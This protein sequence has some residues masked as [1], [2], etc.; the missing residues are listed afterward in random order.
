MSNTLYVNFIGIDVSKNN[1]D[2]YETRTKKSYRIT[3]DA[4]GIKS[5]LKNF[6]PS[7]DLL[8]LIDLTGGYEAAIV[9]HF[10]KKGYNVHRAQGRK[11]RQFAAS[12]GQKAKTDRIDAKML[13]I[14]GEK[15]QETLRLYTV[16]SNEILKELIS[17]REDLKS[18]LQ[19]ENNRKAHFAD[20]IM[21]RSIKKTIAF[22]KEEIA[23]VEEETKERIKNNP[24]LKEKAKAISSVKSVG[25]KTTMSLLA[26]LPELGKANRRQIA[27]L[28]GVAPYANNS[29]TIHKNAR[30]TAGRPIVKQMLFMCALGAVRN[31]CVLKAFYEKLCSKRK[32]KM[33]ALVAVMRKLLI[34][35]NNRCKDFYLQRSFTCT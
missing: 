28:A 33:V 32:T 15:M 21:Q 22:L 11:V 10:Y 31:N 3:N 14:Y 35:L 2:V 18:M 5:L 4:K 19:K 9:N 1:L 23:N 26:A 7:K 8:V 13:T 17:R 6:S 29:G 16:D 20:K 27:A 12:F 24:E 25:L 30:T 34:I